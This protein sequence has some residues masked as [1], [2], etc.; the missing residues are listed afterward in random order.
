MDSLLAFAAET[1]FLRWRT[2]NNNTL[3]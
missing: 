3:Q 2:A 1:K